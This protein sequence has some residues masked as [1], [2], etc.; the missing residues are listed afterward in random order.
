VPICRPNKPLRQQTVGASVQQAGTQTVTSCEQQLHGGL[1]HR[2]VAT[3]GGGQQQQQPPPASAVF[4]ELVHNAAATIVA[5]IHEKRNI[6][7]SPLKVN[8]NA[9]TTRQ[10]TGVQNP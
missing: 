6:M 8:R 3:G 10:S 7:F 5:A 9:C 4:I 1:T 2:V